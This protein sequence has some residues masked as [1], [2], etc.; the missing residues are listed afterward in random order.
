M[1]LEADGVLFSVWGV[2]RN[3]NLECFSNESKVRKF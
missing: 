2:G 3:A 1:E